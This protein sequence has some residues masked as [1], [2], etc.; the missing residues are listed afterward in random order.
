MLF[1][2]SGDRL[3]KAKKFDFLGFG[4]LTLFIAAFQM[5]LDRGP[6]QDWF[7]SAEIWTE[8]D[9]GGGRPLGLRDPHHDHATTRSSIRR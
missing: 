6:G 1:F 9:P 3:A 8:C 7:Q 2:I 5:V 4:M